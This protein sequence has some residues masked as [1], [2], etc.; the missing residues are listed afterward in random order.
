MVRYVTV[1]NHEPFNVVKQTVG[2]SVTWKVCF[3][4]VRFTDKV[5]RSWKELTPVRCAEG[6][7]LC[8]S[9]DR[10]GFFEVWFFDTAKQGTQVGEHLK[11]DIA[12]CRCSKMPNSLAFSSVLGFMLNNGPLVTW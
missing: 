10:L 11:Q 3:P 8:K 9:W 7:L 6:V 2:K 1:F 5:R 12:T 4:V